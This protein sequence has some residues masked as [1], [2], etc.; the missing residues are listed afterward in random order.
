M[1]LF[2]SGSVQNFKVNN[3]SLLPDDTL[4]GMIL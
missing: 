3:E 1:M 2:V 4:V